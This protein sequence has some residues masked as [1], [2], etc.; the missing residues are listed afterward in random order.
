LTE[1]TK[2]P[3]KVKRN[4]TGTDDLAESS[5]IPQAADD[6]QQRRPCRGAEPDT[7]FQV[8]RLRFNEQDEFVGSHHKAC[9]KASP[10]CLLEFPPYFSKRGF[11]I[12]MGGSSD[13]CVPNE[14]GMGLASK[15]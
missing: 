6:E 11:Q 7:L 8:L 10:P 13:S 2:K 15:G 5:M 14:C 3:G 1:E 9:I 12:K 4:S